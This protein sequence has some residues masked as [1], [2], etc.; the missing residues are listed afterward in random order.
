MLTIDL[1]LKLA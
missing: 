1:T